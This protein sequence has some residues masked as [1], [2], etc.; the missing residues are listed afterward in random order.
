MELT[1]Q[2][3]GRLERWTE[4]QLDRWTVLAGEICPSVHPSNC[5]TV[6]LSVYLPAMP[7]TDYIRH[8]AKLARQAQMQ[9]A[10]GETPTLDADFFKA[11]AK[12]LDEVAEGL[13][14]VARR[15]RE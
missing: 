7:T 6:Q 15:A 4:G 11:L 3:A 8:A 14:Q 9:A 12:A 10:M 13:E 5:P 1:L 2:T